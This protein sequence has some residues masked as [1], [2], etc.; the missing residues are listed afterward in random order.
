[1]K[2][3]EV[4]ETNPAIYYILGGNA[5]P[6]RVVS[7]QDMEAF[8]FKGTKNDCLA[9]YGF[10]SYVGTTSN[11]LSANIVQGNGKVFWW[12]TTKDF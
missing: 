4:D 8:I 9:Y 7:G 11:A 10:A 1:V 12:G 5:A 2:D 6:T 3:L